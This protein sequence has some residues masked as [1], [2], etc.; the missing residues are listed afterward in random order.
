MEIDNGT[1]VD[2]DVE[3]HG[4]ECD[5]TLLIYLTFIYNSSAEESENYF[6][7]FLALS[8]DFTTVNLIRKDIHARLE[9]NWLTM[10]H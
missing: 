8:F 6:F 1:A 5:V 9:L 3:C 2:F 7:F 4:C 10:T